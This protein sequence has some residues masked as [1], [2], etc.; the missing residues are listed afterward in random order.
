VVADRSQ[1]ALS[2]AIGDLV[3]ADLDEAAEP[4][5]VELV[6]GCG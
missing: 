3:D 2:L 5:G 1:V 4:P 6:S